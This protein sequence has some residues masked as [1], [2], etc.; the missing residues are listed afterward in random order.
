MNFSWLLS[1]RNCFSRQKDMTNL[2]SNRKSSRWNTRCPLITAFGVA[3]PHLPSWERQKYSS[4]VMEKGKWF[5]AQSWGLKWEVGLTGVLHWNSFGHTPDLTVS[6]LREA[7]K[8]KTFSGENLKFR[9]YD[10]K[11]VI[12]PELGD[13]RF[14]EEVAAILKT[15]FKSESRIFG[16]ICTKSYGLIVCSSKIVMK[17]VP[18]HIKCPFFF[19]IYIDAPTQDTQLPCSTV[20]DS[21]SPSIKGL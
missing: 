5:P 3:L 12:V 15:K 16:G 13:E 1:S 14:M 8:W 20:S 17:H 7:H 6:S 21:I 19:L 10:G 11:E 18:F 4:Q 9:V 2:L